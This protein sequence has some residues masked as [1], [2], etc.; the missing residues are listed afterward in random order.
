VVFTRFHWWEEMK[1]DLFLAQA[2]KGRKIK[3][4]RGNDLCKFL[5]SLICVVGSDV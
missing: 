1:L 2:K 4:I 5:A 3:T